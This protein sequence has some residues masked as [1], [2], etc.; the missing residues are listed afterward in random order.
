VREG[1]RASYIGR[2]NAIR[3]QNRGIYADRKFAENV[4]KGGI[5]ALAAKGVA[6]TPKGIYAR[7]AVGRIADEASEKAFENDISSAAVSMRNTHSDPD[8]QIPN[9][10]MELTKAIEKGD[11]IKARAAQSILL[12]SGGAGIDKLNETLSD[13]EEKKD[14]NI[15]NTEVGKSLRTGLNSAGL[16]GKDNSL[17]TWAYS[18]NSIES[19]RNGT[20][21][22]VKGKMVSAVQGLNAVELAGQRGSVIS[23]AVAKNLI[24]PEQAQA[25]LESNVS[26]DMDANKKAL[27]AGVAAKAAAGPAAATGGTTAGD[28][29]PNVVFTP[30]KDRQLDR[31]LIKTMGAENVAGYADKRGGVGALHDMDIIS[32]INEH[33]GTPIGNQAREEA[34][35]RNLIDDTP[36]RGPDTMPRR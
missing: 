16:K 15:R 4:S 12:N 28:A 27:F 2:G 5:G 22:D 29:Q 24:S 17:A 32:V 19:I 9:V 26:K 36:K 8:K 1:N 18:N 25:V 31:D 30:P 35:R 23:A 21:T 33:G 13:Y 3:K 20:A 10:A 7:N 6:F 11:K 34:I 14:S